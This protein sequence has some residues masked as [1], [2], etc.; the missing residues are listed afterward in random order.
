MNYPVKIFAL[1]PEIIEVH[2]PERIEE[3]ILLDILAFKACI[4]RKWKDKIRSI[5]HGYQVLG[6]QLNEGIDAESFV[7]ILRELKQY[8]RKNPELLP[9]EWKLPV[10]YDRDLVP[11][12]Q[13]YLKKSGLKRS[14]FIE[15][16]TAPSYLLY[17][18]GFLPGFMY[19]GGLD[20]ELH[21]PRKANPER[22]IT[23][24]SVAIGGSQTGVYPMDSPGGWYVVGR[25][26][27]GFLQNGKLQLPFS[28]G[29]RV[30]FEA[31]PRKAYEEIVAMNDFNWEKTAYHG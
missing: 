11:E 8:S 31:I 9:V 23:K 7:P 26:P 24:G 3:E 15:K 13:E 27:V 17:F 6:I 20:K 2:W 4:T 22:K 5:H 30:R 16:H 29:D 19:L 25:C 28:P 18:Y 21:V 1:T 10:C 14:T 12:L